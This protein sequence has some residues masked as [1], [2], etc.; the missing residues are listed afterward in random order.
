[1]EPIKL[2]YMY[3]SF[4]LRKINN[5]DIDRS[6]LKRLLKTKLEEGI[7]HQEIKIASLGTER[8]DVFNVIDQLEKR[9]CKAYKE[10]QSFNQLGIKDYMLRKFHEESNKDDIQTHTRLNHSIGTALLGT[11]YFYALEPFIKS[12]IFSNMT[13]DTKIVKLLNF[14]LYLHD[15]GHLPFSHLSEEVFRELN[16]TRIKGQTHRH[17]EVPL[18]QISK[19]DKEKIKDALTEIINNEKIEKYLEFT[20]DLIGGISG[21]PFLDAIVNSSLDADK[22][23]YIFRDM[24]VTN[25]RARIRYEKEWLTDFLSNISLSPEGFVRL[26]GK[27]SLCALELLEERQFL[28]RNL[29]LRPDIRAFEK[30]A[31]VVLITWLVETVS[32]EVLK[33]KITQNNKTVSLGSF[34][35]DLRHQKGDK[36]SEKIMEEFYELPPETSR[37]INLLIKMCDNLN[38][39]PYMDSC[40][41]DWFKSIKEKFKVFLNNKETNASVKDENLIEIVE[42]PFYIRKGEDTKKA[43]EIARNIYV[44]YPCGILIDIVELPGF[45]PY[46]RS[47]H[48]N[49]SSEEIVSENFLAPDRDPGKWSRSKIG[50]FPLHLCDFT[51]FE[52]RYAQVTVINTLPGEIRGTYF[53]DLFRR[54]CKAQ[55]I[56]FFDYIWR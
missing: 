37:E 48:F 35:P 22:I 34:E 38:D 42:E 54:K 39:S 2:S 41:K 19:K 40:A 14:A 29:Y 47:R 51:K 17:D 55:N 26:N 32:N 50:K 24:S 53:Y 23:D 21:I 4:W 11:L 1:M 25:T 12:T 56:E 10:M 8:R 33:E 43:S 49:F 44:E 13:K 20:K 52:K 36:A 45:L 5:I 6:N 7:E 15:V 18:E 9:E 31:K 27:A 30:I 3:E 28:Y 46:S 16:W